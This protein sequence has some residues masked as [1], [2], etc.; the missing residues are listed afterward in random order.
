[1]LKIQK[2]TKENQQLKN[3]IKS[4]KQEKQNNINFDNFKYNAVT[5]LDEY[6]DILFWKNQLQDQKKEKQELKQQKENPEL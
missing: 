5:I 6:K 3:K 1:M 2:L 4:L